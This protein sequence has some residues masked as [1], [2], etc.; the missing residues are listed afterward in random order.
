MT[1]RA[2]RDGDGYRLTG[3]K[4]WST[5][6]SEAD[7]AV[8]W[9]KTEDDVVRGFLVD[10]HQK[11]VQ[12]PR[13]GDKW[14]LRAAITSEILFDDVR[15]RADEVL[16]GVEGLRGPLSCLTQARYGIAWGVV[17]AAMSCYDAAVQHSRA[18][19]QFD[20]PIGRFQLVQQRLTDMVQEI[21][22]AQL[23]NLRLGQ[24]K[25]AGTM[26]PQQVSL[27]KRNNCDM[28]LNVA[29]SARQV[30]GGNGVLSMYPVMRHMMNLESVVTYEGTHEVHTL[31]VGQDVT[32]EN[33]FA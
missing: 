23:L 25:D 15:V 28:A 3:Y 10:L 30:L 17:G 18:R 26:C 19:E 27:A 12:T 5:N 11:G 24:L 29:R 4:R 2:V 20:R 16:P 13:I 8:V 1:T 21:T 22:K 32:G 31:V 7:V 9:A 14:S 33:A 6:A